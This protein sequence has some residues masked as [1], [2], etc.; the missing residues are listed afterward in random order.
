MEE[1]KE[2]GNESLYRYL[3]SIKKDDSEL[4]VFGNHVM[5]T[6]LDGIGITI[7]NIPNFNKKRKEDDN[8]T[9]RCTKIKKQV[10]KCNKEGPVDRRSYWTAKERLRWKRALRNKKSTNGDPLG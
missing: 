7:F 10:R 4:R 6:S 3:C 9:R 5:I 8:G 2:S 1:V